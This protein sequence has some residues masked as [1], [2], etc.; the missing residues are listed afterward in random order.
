MGENSKTGNPSESSRENESSHDKIIEKTSEEITERESDEMITVIEASNEIPGDIIDFAV[1][2]FDADDVRNGSH[3]NLHL[4]L[5]RG[6]VFTELIDY[7]MKSDIIKEIATQNLSLVVEMVLPNGK[8]EVA[9]DSGG[10]FRDMLTEFWTTFK[11]KCTEGSTSRVPFIR[12]NLTEFH[13]VA[14]AWVLVTG[15]PRKILPNIPSL[16]VFNYC[17]RWC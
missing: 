1:Q 9:E 6:Q 15:S 8:S 17:Y 14:I 13:W 7:I 2:T 3:K 5:H 16:R 11:E 10:V 4:K 12:H